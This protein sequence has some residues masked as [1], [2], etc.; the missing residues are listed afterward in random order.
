MVRHD[1]V[2]L[3][4]ADASGTRTI[5]LTK[6]LAPGPAVG[7]WVGCL[8]D[9][10][11]VV[12]AR[13]SLLQ[14][15]TGRG[16]QRRVLAA[17]VDRAL[18]VCG[19]DRPV[20]LGRLVREAALVWD[21]GAEPVVVLAKATL[22]DA[23]HE[24]A[25][26]AR[27]ACPGVAVLVTSVRE[28]VGLADL[29][30]V[31]SDH[32]CTMIGESGAGKSTLL[33]AMAG[34]EVAATGV[35][36]TD[37]K[38]RHTTTSRDLHVLPG[39]GVLIDMP[40]IRSVGLAVDEEAVGKAFPDIVELAEGCRFRDC[41]HAPE[42]GC[43]VQEAVEAGMLGPARLAAWNELLEEVRAGAAG[44]TGGSGRRS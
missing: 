6:R 18:L 9:E 33:N 42:P 21:A 34:T 2:A 17:N 20:K 30:E 43:A 19:L 1:G 31:L 24:A 15:Q 40:G 4:V 7:D 35:V 39:G 28:G 27:A 8:G 5:P 13:R 3:V 29:Q 22:H 16:D 37:G 36:R 26:V 23:P 44:S 12:L 38:G 32:T 41:A 14:R 11:R 25:A 10:P